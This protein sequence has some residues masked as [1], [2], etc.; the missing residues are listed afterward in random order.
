MRRPIGAGTFYPGDQ[1][2]L[3]SEL[4]MFFQA[5]VEHY[6]EAKGIIVPHAGYLFSGPVAAKVY[7]SISSTQKRNFVILGVDHYGIGIIATSKEDWLTPLGPAKL[8]LEMIKKIGREHA[9]MEDTLA[10]AQEHSIEVQLPFLQYAFGNF[11]FVP[12]QIPRLSYNEVRDLAKVI[13]DK[14]SFFIV[15]SDLTHYGSNYGFVPKES[16]YGPDEFVRNLDARIIE[17]IK[18]GDAKKFMEFIEKNDY[19]VCGYIP[20]AVMMELSKLIGVRRIEKVAYD[21]SFSVSHDTSAIVGYGGM[22]F[23]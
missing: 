7:K 19:T 13:V 23:V 22:V 8:N 21:S 17:K 18:E 10:T 4:E 6:P 15:S 1:K 2:E 5:S 3:I 12:L 9:I 20:I 11:T 14:D 16:I